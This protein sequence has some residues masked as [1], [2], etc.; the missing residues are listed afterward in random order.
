M[1]KIIYFIATVVLLT[2]MVACNDEDLNPTLTED[3]DLETN[4]S[5]YEDV[6]ALLNGAYNRISSGSYY[7]RDYIIINEVRTDNTY[8]N[9]NS[10]RFV[11]EGRM[12]ILPTASNGAWSQI[13]RVIAVANALIQAEGVSGDAALI[14]HAKGQ[15]YAMR[16]L[17][18]FD[19]VK[20]YGQQHVSGGDNT[21][22]V[23]YVT[24]YR[25][26][27]NYFQSRNTV[28]EVKTLALQDLDTALSLMSAS[29][30]D[31]SKQTI[32]THA[33]NAIKAKIALYFGDLPTA[34]D[35]ALKVINSNAFTIASASGF[36][37]TFST[38]SASN[39]IFEIAASG[40]DN[41]GI[42]GLANIYRGASYGDIAVLQ[43]LKDTYDSNDIRG[44]SQFISTVGGFIRNVGKYPTMGTFDDNISVIRYEEVV[45]IYAES[46]IAENP[47]LALTHLN[48]IPQNRNAVT[49]PV[50]TQTNV[51]VERR[52]EFAFE[53]MRFHDLARTGKDIPL[54]DAINQ[55][56]GGPAYGSFNFAYPI[57]NE[58]AGVNANVVQNFGY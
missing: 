29:L 37:S 31:A 45:L 24:T 26:P 1:K 25:N 11:E 54:V 50:A 14:N 22:G 28:A 51:L 46:I 13:Y 58:E 40:T 42:N 53:G 17:G 5:T 56:H 57:P 35:A 10:N 23:P 15:A 7:G 32:T 18:H 33:V 52:K 55:T 19:L 34:R 49:Y 3:K 2:S 6:V 21:L 8:S 47:T 36:A 38:D 9:A 27:D 39:S 20:L 48:S 43:D 44:G 30:N 4:I 41:L 12:N 16:A